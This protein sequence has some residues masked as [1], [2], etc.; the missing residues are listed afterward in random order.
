MND[1]IV[2]KVDVIEGFN[3]RSSKVENE[4][5]MKLA[6]RYDKPTIAGSDAHFASEIG[7]GISTITKK[8]KNEDMHKLLLKCQI[9]ENNTLSP[10]YFQSF[11]QVIK[12]IKMRKYKTIPLQFIGLIMNLVREKWV[13]K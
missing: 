8:D 3:A 9:D 1:E 6:K 5:S 7:R 12:S 10:L 11:S 13:K 4:K 2:R